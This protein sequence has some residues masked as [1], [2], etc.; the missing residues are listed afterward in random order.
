M[1]IEEFM[2]VKFRDEGKRREIKGLGGAEG[3]ELTK[4]VLLGCSSSRS[5]LLGRTA[6]KFYGNKLVQKQ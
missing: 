3:K 4:K 6:S 5:L 2:Q 1:V